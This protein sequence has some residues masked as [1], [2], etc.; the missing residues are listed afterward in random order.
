MENNSN[1]HHG[2]EID[3]VGISKKLLAEKKLLYRFIAVFAIIGIVVA[4]SNPKQYTSEVVLAPE[5]DSGM[6]MAGNVS[7]LA[8]MVGIDVSGFASVDAIHPDIYPDVFA[9]NDFIVELFDVPVTTLKDNVT[10][11]YYDHLEKDSKIP[12]WA[13]P[14]ILIQ[15]ITASFSSK[16]TIKGFE[17]PAMLS[18]KQE[19]ICKIIKENISCLIDKKTSVITISVTDND[20]LV[21]AIMADTLQNRLQQYIMLYRTKKARADVKYAEML[22]KESKEDYERAQER[23]AAYVE[24]YTNTILQSYITKREKLENEL[25]LKLGTY[26]QI[27]QQLQ[28]AKAKVQ[29]RTPAFTVIQNAY[30][31]LKA[32]SIP[33]AFVVILFIIIG[34]LVDAIWIMH[35][36]SYIQKR[37]G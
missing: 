27:T 36:R 18:K 32:S 3:I 13:Y 22:H 11:D 16:D 26:N 14:G 37:K 1:K 29:E 12:F 35:I 5:M 30:V 8:A 33:R 6:G 24:S 10:K 7:D 17:K 28:I 31:P 2:M 4:L 20:P 23:Y 9:S 34:I 19:E 21:A 15:K 25:Q